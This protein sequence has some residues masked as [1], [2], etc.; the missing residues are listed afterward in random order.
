MCLDKYKHIYNICTY[1]QTGSTG[2]NN[3]DSPLRECT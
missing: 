2:K 3:D 1:Y